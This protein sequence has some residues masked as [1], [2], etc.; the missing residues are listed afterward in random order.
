M[1]FEELNAAITP[2][3]CLE[4]LGEL[5]GSFSDGVVTYDFLFAAKLAGH[6]CPTVLSSFLAAD[7]VAKALYPDSLPVRGEIKIELKDKKDDGTTGVTGSIF[8][9]IFGASDEGGFKGLGGIYARNLRLFFDSDIESFAKFTRLDNGKSVILDFDFSQIQRILGLDLSTAIVK[10][11]NG[12]DI[13][14]FKSKWIEKLST[15]ASNF[16][17]LGVALIKSTDDS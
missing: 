11:K 8:S 6:G 9:A 3:K 7:R 5:L 1:I 2:I 14:D 10:F 16:D 15:I 4:P 17:E 13:S 12:D